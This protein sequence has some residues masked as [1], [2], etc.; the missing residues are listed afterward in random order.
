MTP[1]EIQ[2]SLDSDWK[3]RPGNPL[4]AKQLGSGRNNFHLP[5][6]RNATTSEILPVDGLKRSHIKLEISEVSGILEISY[7]SSPS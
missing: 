3:C 4:S 6:Y 1:G 5:K 2:E 7:K